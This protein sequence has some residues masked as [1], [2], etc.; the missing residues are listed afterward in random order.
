MKVSSH[1]AVDHTITGAHLV[2]V[3]WHDMYHSGRDPDLTEVSYIAMGW[4][5]YRGAR[6][7][8]RLSACDLEASEQASKFVYESVGLP[9]QC[10]RFWQEW[11]SESG[12]GTGAQQVMGA[13]H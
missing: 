3:F 13:W 2:A 1:A 5:A 8:H 10:C 4:P 11:W 6:D 9:D 7:L 12:I